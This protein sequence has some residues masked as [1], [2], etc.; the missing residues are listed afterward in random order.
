M[1]R[2]VPLPLVWFWLPEMLIFFPV[3]DLSSWLEFP[4]F[5]CPCE[6]LHLLLCSSLLLTLP[7]GTPRRW[8]TGLSL[9]CFC[10]VFVLETH[11]HSPCPLTA[12]SLAL[13]LGKCSLTAFCDIW[14]TVSNRYTFGALWSVSF[15]RVMRIVPRWLCHILLFGDHKFFLFYF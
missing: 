11:L 8:Q 4:L 1:P 14:S 10:F 5:W 13:W 2:K 9:T 12:R 3:T 6:G 15:T 7:R